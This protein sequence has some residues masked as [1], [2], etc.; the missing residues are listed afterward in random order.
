[1]VDKLTASI[2]GKDHAI[3]I[4]IDLSKAFNNVDHNI[5]LGKLSNYGI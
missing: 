1:M 3:G 2:D 4:F 5:L